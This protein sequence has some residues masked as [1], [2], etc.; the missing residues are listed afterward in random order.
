MRYST[1]LFD[2][3]HMLLD[4]AS[5]EQLAFAHTMA[6][7]GVDDPDKLFRPYVAIN[8]ALWAA[9][10]RNEISPDH[11]RVTRFEQLAASQTLDANPEQMADT[12][13]A[14]LSNYGDLFPGARDLLDLLDGAVTMALVTNGIGQ[15][16]RSRIERLDLGRYFSAVSIS[17]DIGSSKPDRAIFEHAFETMS[18]PDPSQSVMVG[19]SLSSDIKGGIDYGIDTCWFNPSRQEV[20]PITPTYDVATFADLHDVLT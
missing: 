4:S 10:E 18:W 3:D 16:Q 13:A 2:L 15:I 17:G 8:K 20:G 1:V 14:G 11:V 6:S 7:I 12:F 5:S 19:D 9:V